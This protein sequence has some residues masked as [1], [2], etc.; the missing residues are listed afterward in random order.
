MKL[1]WP[2]RMLDHRALGPGA[3]VADPDR[4]AQ[5]VANLANNALTCGT[6]DEAVTFTTEVS[7]DALEIRVHNA[8]RPIPE[9]LQRQIFEPLRRGAH[10][11]KLGSRSVG[12]GLYIVRA[13]ATAHGGDVRVSST[14][15]H[16]TT[17]VVSLPRH[18][19]PI[20]APPGSAAVRDPG[21]ARA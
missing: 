3:A 5:M 12:L 18:P 13:I 1:T 9:E 20:A 8:G 2:G 17:F 6:P 11:V 4:L 21:A 14:E 15:G 19:R 10:H 16:G 7:A